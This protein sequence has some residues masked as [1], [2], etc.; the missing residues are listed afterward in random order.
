MVTPRPGLFTEGGKSPYTLM[1]KWVGSI[2]SPDIL[3]KT[4]IFVPAG[5]RIPDSSDPNLVTIPTELC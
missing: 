5:V 4:K 2:I 3:E 1:G